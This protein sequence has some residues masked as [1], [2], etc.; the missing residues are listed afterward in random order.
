VLYA[1]GTY[2][3]IH[4]ESNNNYWRIPA[5]WKAIVTDNKIKQWQVYADNII[6]ADIMNRNK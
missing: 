5:A 3:G 4:N 2:K 6:V 1:S